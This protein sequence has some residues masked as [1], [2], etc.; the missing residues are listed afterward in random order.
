[1]KEQIESALLQLPLA[2]ADIAALAPSVAAASVVLKQN[3]ALKPGA[4]L[5]DFRGK[6]GAVADYYAGD[7]LTLAGY[8]AAAV[9]QPSLFSLA[10]AT[11][12]GHIDA[13]ASHFAAD[14][15]SL[16]EYLAAAVRQPALFSQA[17]ATMQANIEAVVSH[18][19][20]HG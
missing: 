12:I 5:L 16:S 18:F 3:K 17:P 6:L 14:G 11:V 19:Q 10:P 2:E 7:G 4:S 9:R 13:V 8:L 20:P 15:L 1:M